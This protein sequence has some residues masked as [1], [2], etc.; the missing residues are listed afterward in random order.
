MLDRSIASGIEKIA[1]TEGYEFRI[2]KCLPRARLPNYAV[3]TVLLIMYAFLYAECILE[4]YLLRIRRRIMS[5]YYPRREK[6]RLLYLRTKILSKRGIGP[7]GLESLVKN[8]S[9]NSQKTREMQKVD[10]FAK[11]ASGK[12]VSACN[13]VPRMVAHEL[14]T[15]CYLRKR[16]INDL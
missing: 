5:V 6:A 3:H 13:T 1:S 14:K 11:Y 9:L 8:A 10:F 15:A 2:D 7:G 4:P 16:R 12:G